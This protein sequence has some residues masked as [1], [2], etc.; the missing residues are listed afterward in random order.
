MTTAAYSQNLN[1]KSNGD[2]ER[3]APV[4]NKILC[5]FFFF[6]KQRLRLGLDK[7]CGYSAH[8]GIN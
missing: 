6:P 5:F 8:S 3:E 4:N 1:L 2:G 7:I